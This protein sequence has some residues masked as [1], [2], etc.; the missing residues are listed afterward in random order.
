MPLGVQLQVM[1]NDL[2][3]EA[4]YSTLAAHGVNQLEH[5]KHLLI[6]Q[7]RLLHE[8]YD[9]PFLQKDFDKDLV[10]GVDSYSYPDGL[11]FNRVNYLSAKVGTI[12]QP[13][14]YGIGPSEQSIYNSEDGQRGWPI[15]RWMADADDMGAFRVWPL[16]S[17]TGT[18]RFRG[19]AVLKPFLADDDVCTLD[20]DMIVLFVAAE[21]LARSKQEDAPQKLEKAQQLERRLRLRQE[22]NKKSPFVMGGGGDGTHRRP[23]AGID[24]IPMGYGDG[25]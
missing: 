1:V 13:V 7:Q 18:I 17:Q 11:D 23:R 9:W 15:R 22:A 3:L 21:L 6:R 12:W 5:L 14:G 16:P 25:S 2:K 20:S 24:Y 10:I 19:Q 8:G 4:G